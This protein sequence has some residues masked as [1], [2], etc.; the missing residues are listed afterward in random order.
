MKIAGICSGHDCSYGILEN[1]VP[2][3]HNELERFNRKKEPIDDAFKFLFDTY[4][5]FNDIKHFSYCLNTWRNGI[6][7]RYPD[8][9]NTMRTIRDNNGGKF[10]EPGHHEC[11]AANA[12]FSSNF[13]ESLI[14]TIDGGGEDYDYN[15]GNKNMLTA[16]TSWYGK[17]NQ[18]K[19][20]DIVPMDSCNIG[21][22]WNKIVREVFGLSGTGGPLGSQAGTVMAMAC[23]TKEEKFYEYFKTG[24]FNLGH[25]NQLI[26]ASSVEKYEKGCVSFDIARGWQKYTEKIIK[27]K[28][29][30][31]I[32]DYEKLVGKTPK[33]LCLSGGVA[34]NSVAVGKMYDWFPQIKN[35]YVDPVPYDAGIALGG[36]RLIW[37][38]YLGN[39]RIKWEDNASPYLGKTYNNNEIKDA[40]NKFSS[41]VEFSN[42]TDEKV[43]DLLLKDDNVISVFGGGSESGRRALGNRSI[44]AD[45]RSP[46]MKDI[47]NEKVKHR[48]WFRPFAPSIIR[49]AV[50]DW[51]ERDID[52]PYMTA[53]IK[54]KESVRNKVP[55]VVHYD[56]SAR[57]QTVTENDNKW[58][59]N[60]IKRFGEKTGVPILLN[61][62]FNDREP[63]VETPEHAINC[64]LGTDIDYLYFYNENI[65]V[66]K[67]GNK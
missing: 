14:V 7:N 47:I 11:H 49:E 28:I 66:Q 59:Y 40:L 5:D 46:D 23:M 56:G 55:A 61:T 16:F 1:G 2:V 54:F 33:N 30:N 58:Y 67:R 52:S 53:V 19:L 35:I 20:I 17:D 22:S 26:E 29:N 31:Y 39:P 15:N 42:T 32:L 38:Q 37:H 63:I 41:E 51:F 10:Y 9:F 4:E 27:E 36:P 34:L 48:Q 60:F 8:S 12:F 57:L 25:L 62:S 43:I 3:I 65:L 24:N 45:P 64:F 21:S 6:R 13:D 50:G 44:L 18:I